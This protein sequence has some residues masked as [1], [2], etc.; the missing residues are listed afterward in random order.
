MPYQRELL[1]LPETA[2]TCER[3]HELLGGLDRELWLDWQTCL[4][5]P[6]EEARAAMH[7]TGVTVPHLDSR[8]KASKTY[9]GF[10]SDLLA[11]GLI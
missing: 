8:L 3:P 4:C 2:G 9:A 7:D 11:R 6:P 5:V 1:S 10:L